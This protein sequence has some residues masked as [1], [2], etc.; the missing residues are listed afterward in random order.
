MLAA[1]Q[2]CSAE[3]IDWKLTYTH[4]SAES[5]PDAFDLNLRG[6][7]GATV[8]WVGYYRRASEF[9]QTRIGLERWL[10]YDWGK[11][12]LSGQAATHGF[13]GFASQAEIGK[14][15]VRLLAGFGRT[16][17][18]S[19]YNL[20]FDPNDAITLGVIADLPQDMRASVFA[21]HDDRLHTGQTVIHVLL[22][23]SGDPAQRWTIDASQ[24][25]GPLGDGGERVHRTGVAVTFDHA[26]YFA[27]VAFDPNANFSGHDMVRLGF[28]VRF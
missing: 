16:N 13:L 28:G 26:P 14:D 25:R 6:T 1:A 3:S 4:H 24:R 19:Y 10:T 23:T 20:N 11:L 27:R 22:R 2:S 15:S 9:E 21:V 18:R 5:E 8:F 12:L 7:Y 17:L